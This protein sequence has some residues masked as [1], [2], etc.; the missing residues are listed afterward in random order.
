MKH[1]IDCIGFKPIRKGTLV[2]FADIVIREL[3]LT[4]H[5]VGLHE[6]GSSRFASPPSRPWVKDGQVVT[7]DAGKTQYV[8]IIEFADRGTRDAFSQT[9]WRAV[10]KFDPDA[11]SSL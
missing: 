7:D 1:S 6:K 4:I 11:V 8:Q 2:G 3:K 10:E 9:V 5:D